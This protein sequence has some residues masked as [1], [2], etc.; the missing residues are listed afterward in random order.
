VLV[1]SFPDPSIN[2]PDRHRAAR[3]ILTRDS[4]ACHFFWKAGTKRGFL[5][6]FSAKTKKQEQI[7]N[8]QLIFKILK[9]KFLK[10]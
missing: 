3:F 4:E 1:F 7:V 10:K 8:F 2:T 5:F 9:S 6:S